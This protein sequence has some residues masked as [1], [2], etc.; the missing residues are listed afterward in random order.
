[1]E[2]HPLAGLGADPPLHD[3]VDL[4]RDRGDVAGAIAGRAAAQAG[5]VSRRL[6]DAIRPLL[7][8]EQERKFD[9]LEEARVRLRERWKTGER[10]TPEQREW[11]RDRIEQRYGNRP[12]GDDRRP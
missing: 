3:A 4:G 8:A 2:P 12:R 7:D 1:M 6:D 9:R 11:L 10:L 5:Q